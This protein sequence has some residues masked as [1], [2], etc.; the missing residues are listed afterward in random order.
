MYLHCYVVGWT[1]IGSVENVYIYTGACIENCYLL[2]GTL[3]HSLAVDSIHS[4]FL[5]FV[6]LNKCWKNVGYVLSVAQVSIFGSE[7]DIR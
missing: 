6:L 2:I 4:I 3:L 7:V 1:V 5:F